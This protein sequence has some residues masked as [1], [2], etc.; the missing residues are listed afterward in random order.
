MFLHPTMHIWKEDTPKWSGNNSSK[1]C[2][3]VHGKERPLIFDQWEACL[4]SYQAVIFQIIIPGHLNLKNLIK[5]KKLTQCKTKLNFQIGF[6]PS[7]MFLLN[8]IEKHFRY[9]HYVMSVTKTDLFSFFSAIK[10]QIFS[11]AWI[12]F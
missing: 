10:I 12:L 9:G 7:W 4:S 11:W 5:L 3:V 8:K 6:G 2:F 1:V